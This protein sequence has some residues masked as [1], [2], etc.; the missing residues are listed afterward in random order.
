MTDPDVIT[1]LDVLDAEK[2]EFSAYV[3][4]ELCLDGPWPAYDMVR[5]NM[6]AWLCWTCNRLQRLEFE[7]QLRTERGW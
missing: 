4:C 1:E 3:V 5:D 7:D 6:G 2:I